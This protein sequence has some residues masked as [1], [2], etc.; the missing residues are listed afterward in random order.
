MKKTGLFQLQIEV[1][2]VLVKILN[3]LEYNFFPSK[4]VK[5]AS[6]TINE[7]IRVIISNL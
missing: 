6:K 2:F 1:F 5:D 7:K 4:R 3:I